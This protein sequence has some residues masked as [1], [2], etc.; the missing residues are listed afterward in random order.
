VLED[1]ILGMLEKESINRPSLDAV[2]DAL[3]QARFEMGGRA[4]GL[5]IGSGPVIVPV[6]VSDR[7]QATG[8]TTGKTSGTD[9]TVLADTAHGTRTRRFGMITGGFAM[10]F[11]LVVL[12]AFSHDKPRQMPLAPAAASP[13]GAAVIT[14]LT[15]ALTDRAPGATPP[16]LAPRAVAGKKPAAQPARRPTRQRHIDP[17]ATIDPFG[18]YGH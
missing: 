6:H 1:L 2:I 15:P 5:A 17:N 3:S 9:P 10:A 18:P 16:T 13:A 14:P 11:A 8:R 7:L 4:G 12:A